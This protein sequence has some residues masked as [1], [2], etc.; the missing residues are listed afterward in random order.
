MII[1]GTVTFPEDK[2]N[3]V[4]E[5]YNSLPVLPDFITAVGTYVYNN[6]GE[7]HRAFTIFKFDQARG[8]EAN[9]YFQARKDAFNKIETLTSTYEEWLDVQDALAIVAEGDYDLSTF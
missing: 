5:C 1:I 2:E 6:P 3:E 9:A 7:K 8:D 4:A